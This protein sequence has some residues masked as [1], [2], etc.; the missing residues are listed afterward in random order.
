MSRLEF[1]PNDDGKGLYVAS[2]RLKPEFVKH[3]NDL[4]AKKQRKVGTM[5]LLNRKEALLSV[6]PIKDCKV[7]IVPDR[8][9]I[10]CQAK[11]GKCIPRGYSFHKYNTQKFVDEDYVDIWSLENNLGHGPMIDTNVIRK[12]KR[13]RVKPTTSEPALSNQSATKEP[14]LKKMRTTEKE[15]IPM[16]KKPRKTSAMK[17]ESTPK[18]L[19]SSSRHRVSNPNPVFRRPK[20]QLRKRTPTHE[21]TLESSARLPIAR[22]KT[23]LKHLL[24][25]EPTT[26][27]RLRLQVKN[28]LGIP[29]M[30]AE[31]L[32]MIASKVADGA[33]S[34]DSICRIKPNVFNALDRTELQSSDFLTGRQIRDILERMG[35]ETGE[36]VK[37]T[38]HPVNYPNTQPYRNP[39]TAT[40][41][42]VPVKL[43]ANLNPPIKK[44][45]NKTIKA[46]STLQKNN[47]AKKKKK[48]NPLPQR[49]KTKKPEPL[50]AELLEE[51]PAITD[52]AMYKLMK[53][54]FNGAHKEYRELT[55]EIQTIKV[56][57]HQCMKD[58]KDA[59]LAF[60]AFKVDLNKANK[61]QGE[62]RAILA[63]L[64]HRVNEF[65]ASRQ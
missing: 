2:F 35:P 19:L 64:K 17:E 33:T 22:I 12:R 41:Q 18:E 49:K 59:F 16:Q 47:P 46:K 30:D 8:E 13:E 32:K 60:H 20:P 54:M 3:I 21:G 40:S 11:D 36:D 38:M 44:L 9:V 55:L 5:R 34:L 58:Q 31:K 37:P 53:E 7:T 62:K 39:T 51:Y 43:S 57:M 27:H 42:K 15:I 48:A 65:V 26:L 1:G 52:V 56:K 24:S 10:F 28:L 14:P 63:V 23:L 61:N 6:K 50:R 4:V 29:K 25:V 45:S